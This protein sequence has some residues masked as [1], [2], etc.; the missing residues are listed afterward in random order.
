MACAPPWIRD[1]TNAHEPKTGGQR[2]FCSRGFNSAIVLAGQ[3]L[4]S[5][6]MAFFKAPWQEQSGVVGM[7]GKACRMIFWAWVA[8]HRRLATTRSAV[9]GASL[10]FQQ[11]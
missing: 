3:H 5:V 6:R 9:T 4:R 11:S 10:V 2:Y 1:R 8:L 7:L